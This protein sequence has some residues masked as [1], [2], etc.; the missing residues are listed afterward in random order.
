MAHP[1]TVF[2]GLYSSVPLNTSAKVVSIS[3]IMVATVLFTESVVVF[4]HP[5][6]PD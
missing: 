4:I 6:L 1:T 5:I 2:I 3:E